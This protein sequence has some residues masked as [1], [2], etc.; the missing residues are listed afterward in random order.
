MQFVIVKNHDNGNF[1]DWPRRTTS[2][3]VLRDKLFNN[4]GNLK[5]HGH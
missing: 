3:K 1:K 4:D 5:H 2:D